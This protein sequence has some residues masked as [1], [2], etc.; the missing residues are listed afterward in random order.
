[1]QSLMQSAAA[2]LATA[3]A[4]V[5]GET[6]VYTCAATSQS[7]QLTAARGRS[8]HEAPS[9][10]GAIL[11]VLSHDWLVDA[12]DLAPLA[13]AS[14][15]YTPQKGDTIQTQAS[16]FF[17]AGQTFTLMSPPYSPSDH[18]ARRLRLHSVR[19]V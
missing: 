18:D 2:A 10:D 3:I 9:T 6:I 1:M 15:S 11:Q 5:A 19:T 8:T 7:V 14:V 12:K 16:E 17:P 13:T 4:A